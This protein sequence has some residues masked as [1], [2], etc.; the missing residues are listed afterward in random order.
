[1]GW[2]IEIDS[3]APGL[4]ALAVAFALAH[5]IAGGSRFYRGVLR[6]Q[7]TGRYGEI[8][9]L[10][11]FLAPT[12]FLSHIVSSYYWYRSGHWGWPPS[13]LYTL[14]GSVPVS[15]FF[16]VT[17]FLFWRR[18]AAAPGR[19]D[20]PALLRSR[21]R[22]LAPLYL[23]CITVIFAV[24]GVET[25]WTFAVPLPVLAASLAHWAT[26]GLFGLP[27][28]N[29]FADTS[30]IDP[31]LWT[32][33]YEWFFYLTLPGLSFLATPRRLAGVGLAVAILSLTGL[34]AA[35]D[36]VAANFL[37]G[38]S[39]AQFAVARPFPAILRS[40]RAALLAL[41]PAVVAGIAGD[42]EFGVLESISLAPL[43]TVVAAGNDLFGALSSRAARCLGLVS[44]STYVLHGVV[45]YLALAAAS[46]VVSVGDLA[47][48]AYWALMLPI[49]AAVVAVSAVSYRWIEHPFLASPVGASVPPSSEPALIRPRAPN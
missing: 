4:L 20:V 35:N 47:P 37:V 46:R 24:V 33:R 36:Y 5:V 45:L 17:G 29:G 1:M 15:L 41:L 31:A 22:R 2:S 48:A 38:M 3:I 10:R 14:C 26:F 25:R 49:S 11:G 8:D 7:A 39:V 32:L 40:R 6:A 43:F 21:L 28:I 44:Y 9:G 42:G 12:V 13:T 16:M 18:A 23:T 27:D 19:M 34:Q 30:L